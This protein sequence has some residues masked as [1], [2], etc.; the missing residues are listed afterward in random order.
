MDSVTEQAA[1]IANS[2]KR[3][4]L[5]W[6]SFLNPSGNSKVI[7]RRGCPRAKGTSEPSQVTALEV[8][9][10]LLECLD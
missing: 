8:G 4:Q 3:S 7:F 6:R 1:S 5:V 2:L 9:V 10:Y